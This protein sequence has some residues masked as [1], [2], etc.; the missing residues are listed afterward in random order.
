[1][2]KDIQ[3]LLRKPTVSV[4]DAGR[5]LGIGRNAAY[6][7]VKRGEIDSL[8]FGK[9]RVVPTAPLRRKLGIETA[10]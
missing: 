2:D 6:D 3:E 10:A 5:V 8:A 9:R 4:P 1:M 7:A